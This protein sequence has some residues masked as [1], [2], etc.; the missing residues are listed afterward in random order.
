MTESKIQESIE[1]FMNTHVED[2]KEKLADDGKLNSTVY[3]LG[4]KIEDDSVGMIVAPIIGN[5]KNGPEFEEFISERVLPSLFSEA[6]SLHIVPICFSTAFE[7]SMTCI[8]LDDD[9]IIEKIA[10]INNTKKV[11]GLAIM[12]ETKD[13]TYARF[14]TVDKDGQSINAKGDLVDNITFA[15]YGDTDKDSKIADGGKYKHLF[16]KYT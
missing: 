12:F 5:V 10:D 6:K 2:I 15:V 13:S 14:F 11:D 4:Y 7:V 16:E 3:M 1:Y 8:K 9:A